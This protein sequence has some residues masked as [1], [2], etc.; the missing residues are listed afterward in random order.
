[1]E[2]PKTSVHILLL[3]VVGI[4]CIS[5]FTST[6]S[7]TTQSQGLPTPQSST[8][9]TPTNGLHG[10]CQGVNLPDATRSISTGV[11]VFV[12]D[13]TCKWKGNAS[14]PEEFLIEMEQNIRRLVDSSLK[15]YLNQQGSS[16]SS[17]NVLE[18]FGTLYGLNLGNYSDPAFIR[19]WFS[20]KMA[21]LLPYAGES[22]LVQLGNQNFSCS[23]YQE[24]MKSMTKELQTI[25]GIDRKLIYSNF[26]KVFLSRK[27]SPEPG[28]AEIRTGSE[29]WLQ[30]NIGIEVVDKL[31][32]QQKA[33]LILDPDS[34]ALENANF[35]REVLTN[36]KLSGRDK[37]L[38]QFF[39]TFVQISQQ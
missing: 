7:N 23:S 36:L 34:G 32:P 24:L 19:L 37:Q 21:P 12:R 35:V 15:A 6:T 14:L 30:R 25:Q 8:A 39:Q 13:L 1:M 4:A 17:A 27:N 26:I 3:L 38:S 9:S 5:S 29:E 11:D 31:S 22:F 10:S 28:C 33:E 20:L 16:E 2:V 18:I